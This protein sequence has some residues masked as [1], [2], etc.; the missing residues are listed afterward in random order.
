[1][2]FA[3]RLFYKPLAKVRRSGGLGVEALAGRW[4]APYNLCVWS[5]AYGLPAKASTPMVISLTE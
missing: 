5:D 4:W 1:M 2:V 3:L